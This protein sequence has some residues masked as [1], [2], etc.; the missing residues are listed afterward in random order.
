MQLPIELMEFLF[1][2]AA[3]GD[4]GDIDAQ[5]FKS[6]SKVQALQKSTPSKLDF[7]H[8]HFPFVPVGLMEL[9]VPLQ[10]DELPGIG[11]CQLLD[12]NIHGGIGEEHVPFLAEFDN[13]HRV[14]LGER[15][16][17]T[18]FL[19]RLLAFGDVPLQFAVEG[20]HLPIGQ[21]LGIPGAHQPPAAQPRQQGEDCN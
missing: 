19:L 14:E 13:R 15:S 2:L 21:R 16:Q 18:D 9:L 11:D 17:M 5:G 10:G 7:H 12:E 20:A 1:R 4:V 8:T 3:G 6:G